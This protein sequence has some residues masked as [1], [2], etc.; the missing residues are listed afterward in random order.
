MKWKRFWQLNYILILNWIV[1]NRTDYIYIKMD[2]ALNNL[3]RLISHKTQETN[4]SESTEFRPDC[5]G[6]LQLQPNFLL[7]SVYFTVINCVFIFSNNII[8]S[9][10][11]P[12]HYMAQFKF[13]KHKFP[14]QMTLFI[15][16]SGFPVIPDVK[17][18]ILCQ[19]T[20]YHNTTNHSRY[21][22]Q[23]GLLQSRN[24]HAAK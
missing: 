9:V 11:S 24:V 17:Q 19:H 7:P 14:N 23:L 15:Q 18:Y 4:Q 2:L 8:F 20:T 5:Q 16:L 13:I 21:L 10:C 12:P 6:S 1:F 22:P 3:Q